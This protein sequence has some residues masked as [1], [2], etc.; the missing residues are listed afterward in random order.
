MNDKPTLEEVKAVPR[1]EGTNE[2]IPDGKWIL[3]F[4]TDPFDMDKTIG[5]Y[6]SDGR[7]IEPEAP[8]Q[9]T[10][11]MK[12]YH[13][14]RETENGLWFIGKHRDGGH[15]EKYNLNN[16]LYM[17]CVPNS[18]AVSAAINAYNYGQRHIGERRYYGE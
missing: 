4:K 2:P 11:E 1:Y 12:H 18:P 5:S 10:L 9:M 15:I 7:I 16:I 14:F 17:E 8:K 13:W 3:L 6:M